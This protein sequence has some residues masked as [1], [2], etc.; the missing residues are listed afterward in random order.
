MNC[1]HISLNFFLAA[2]TAVNLSWRRKKTRSIFLAAYTAVNIL[3]KIN[4]LDVV[5]LAAYTAVNGSG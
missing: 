3:I 5:F 4:L 1:G 2:Y